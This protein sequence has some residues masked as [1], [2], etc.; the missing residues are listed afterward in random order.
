MK[1]KKTKKDISSNLKKDISSNLE[2]EPESSQR[3]VT[4]AT[5]DMRLARL[6][7]NLYRQ[8]RE[9]LK[10]M[11]STSLSYCLDELLR[12]AVQGT[13][14]REAF[15]LVKEMILAS[16]KSFEHEVSRVKKSLEEKISRATGKEARKEAPGR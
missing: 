4:T 16:G 1:I 15:D 13:I 9:P 11:D 3:S 10:L 5:E 8:G 12:R 6:A 7:E 14:Q 2:F